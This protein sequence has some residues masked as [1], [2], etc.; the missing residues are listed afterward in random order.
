MYLYT[1]IGMGGNANTNHATTF[2]GDMT[3]P[4]AGDDHD[5]QMD[6][7]IQVRP[8]NLKKTYRIR[9]LDP[10]HIEKLITLKGIVIRC[11]DVIPEMKEA[12]FTCV[13]CQREERRFIEKGK[14]IEPTLCEGCQSANTFK[15]DHSLCLFSDKQHVKVQETPESVPEGETPQT[16]HL[17]AYED[18]VDEVRPGDRVEITGIYRAMGVRVNPNRRTLKNIYRTYIDVICYQKTDKARV[19]VKDADAERQEEAMTENVHM[20]D[21]TR[22]KQV[23]DQ[24]LHGYHQMFSD[25]EIKRF[26]EFSQQQ[27][28]YDLLI[29]SLAPSIWENKDVKKGILTQLFG[30]VSKELTA[31]GRGR[32]RGEIN[33]LLCG[34]PSTAKSQL[35]QYVHKI[36]PR[37][38]YTSGKGSSAVGLTVYITK[39]PETKEIV[40]ESGAL[41]LSDRGI[42]CIDE[43]DKMD[44]NTR[45]I[46][47]EAMEQQTVSVAKAGIICTLNART[48]ILAAANPIQSKY[49]PKMSVVDNIRLPPTLLSR[50]DLVY[51]ILDH[52]SE[53]SDR[54]LANH[55]VSLY[56]LPSEANIN[57]LK[58]TQAA[59]TLI[60]T[61]HLPRDFL[62]RYVSYA[63]KHCSPVISQKAAEH[64][65]E[66]YKEMRNMG[67]NKKTITATPRQ[68]ESL[69]RISEALA[70]MRLATEVTVKDVQEGVQLIRQAMR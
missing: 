38:I 37:G 67:N 70:K 19:N 69:I 7:M 64:L 55:I 30:W 54:R 60:Q 31:T 18:F 9:E 8:F 62:A 20:E 22:D 29:D 5:Q 50:F 41:V 58:R 4:M 61:N 34:D 51:L 23:A 28:C 68:L 27:D 15:L 63:R 32:F 40:L 39:D 11:S 3:A 33:V 10:T 12:A 45:N 13:K 59:T 47:H 26:K 43:F 35:L 49:N 56:S 6:V 52:Q 25:A 66:Q 53:A 16:I 24:G 1:D 48:A 57:D 65:V 21:V 17:C 14:I 2:G 44:D 36:A 42:C 46:L